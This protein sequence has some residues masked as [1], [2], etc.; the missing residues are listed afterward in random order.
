MVVV[1]LIKKNLAMA[2]R[3]QADALL[4]SKK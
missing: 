1:G 2:D 3:G 4:R